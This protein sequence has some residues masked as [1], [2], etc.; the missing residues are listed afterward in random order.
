M[1]TKIELDCGCSVEQEI[2]LRIPVA[3]DPRHI[4]TLPARF[5]LGKEC[6]ERNCGECGSITSIHPFLK[7]R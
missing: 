1:L 6:T 7:N 5:V 3:E 4:E 2:M